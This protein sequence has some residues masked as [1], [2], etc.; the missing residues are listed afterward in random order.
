MAEQDFTTGSDT[1]DQSTHGQQDASLLTHLQRLEARFEDAYL[2]A[3]NDE[4]LGAETPAAY[5]IDAFYRA[6]ARHLKFGRNCEL[7]ELAA[8]DTFT[9]EAPAPAPAR[10]PRSNGK[11]PS[12]A[13]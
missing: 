1:A 9:A 4:D 5:P 13:L 10:A 3:A 12:Y 2:H 11:G 6:C 8:N 7:E